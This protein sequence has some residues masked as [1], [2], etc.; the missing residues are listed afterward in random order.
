MMHFWAGPCGV[1]LR[2]QSSMVAKCN[3]SAVRDGEAWLR[4]F[5]L[6]V[7]EEPESQD[8]DDNRSQGIRLD[9]HESSFGSVYDPH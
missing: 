4:G 3:I 2:E 9:Q 6:P 1:M 5:L 8:I 7:K